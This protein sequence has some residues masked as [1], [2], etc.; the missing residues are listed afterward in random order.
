MKC[1]QASFSISGLK[2]L[3]IGTE[4]SS[5]GYW[6]LLV[7]S[8][9]ISHLKNYDHTITKLKKLSKMR[10][11]ES[12]RCSTG[13]YSFFAI[14]STPLRDGEKRESCYVD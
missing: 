4:L 1:A 3:I 11:S 6:L 8:E 14:P 13:G 2:E 5:F 9:S 12:Q 10:E 7:I